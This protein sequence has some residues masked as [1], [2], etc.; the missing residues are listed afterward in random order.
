MML[1]CI[2]WNLC[3]VLSCVTASQLHGSVKTS[4]LCMTCFTS[5]I[6]P[7]FQTIWYLVT[8]ALLYDRK[9]K[10]ILCH[11]L[12]TILKSSL[13]VFNETMHATLKRGCG[14]ETTICGDSTTFYSRRGVPKNQIIQSCPAYV[15]TKHQVYNRMRTHQHTCWSSG[16]MPSATFCNT[17]GGFN[18]GNNDI[19]ES[20]KLPIWYHHL[21]MYL[22]L[23]KSIFFPNPFFNSMSQ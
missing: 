8:T 19:S 7:K 5:F 1:Q 15:Q 12:W 23:W 17:I 18:L 21:L 2:L 13:D 20:L 11:T 14:D 6:S 3:S 16:V 9:K 4:A 10:T 22:Y